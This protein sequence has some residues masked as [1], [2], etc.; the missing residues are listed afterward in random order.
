MSS[1]NANRDDLRLL[2]EVTVTDLTYF[3]SQQWTVANYG[4]LTYAALAGIAQIIKPLQPIDRI[5]LIAI[6][7]A[8]CV[9][10]LWV[11][12]KLQTSIGVRQSRLD[13]IRVKLGDMFLMAWSAEYKP[14]ERVHAIH[15]LQGAVPL[16]FIVI[17]W[18]IGFRL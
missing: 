5:V 4:M 10:V 9:S 15:I 7:F 16:G 13:S 12:Q 18:I 8:A 17:A 2:Y 14:K 11:L 1:E 6:A 3:K